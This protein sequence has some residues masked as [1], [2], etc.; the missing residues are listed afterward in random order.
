[1]NY[2]KSV[3]RIFWPVGQGAFY[4]EKLKFDD[5]KEFNIVYDCGS[6]KKE[7]VHPLIDEFF[8]GT[9]IDILFISHFDSDHVNGVPGL[10]NKARIKNVVVPLIHNNDKI[11][12]DFY[13]D[14]INKNLELRTLVSSPEKYFG[15]NTNVIFITPE[16]NYDDSEEPFFVDNANG[17]K[18]INS[19]RRLTIGFLF[20][21]IFTLMKEANS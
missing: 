3:E 10:K 4:S 5:G 6:K 16:N 2:I 11:L 21:I 9:T 7:L 1:M 18:R 12:L 20:L 19:G 8:E 14:K 17:Q 13:Y 15:E